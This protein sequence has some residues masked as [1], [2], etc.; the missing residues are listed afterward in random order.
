MEVF[1]CSV[2]N[3]YVISQILPKPSAGIFKYFQEKETKQAGLA[4]PAAKI[5]EVVQSEVTMSLRKSR[6][7]DTKWHVVKWLQAIGRCECIC[8]ARRASDLYVFRA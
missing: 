4:M 8:A 6:A 3:S 1:S 2:P 5:D 7:Q